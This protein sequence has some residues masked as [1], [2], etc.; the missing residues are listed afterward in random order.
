MNLQNPSSNF[1][2][3]AVLVS[4][5]IWGLYWIPL[6]YLEG[7]GVAEAWTVALINIPAAAAISVLFFVHFKVQKPHLR[8]G[9][10][11]GIF[12][13]L[14]VAM[15][16][17]GLVHSSVVRVTLLFYLTPVWS[18]LIGAY[19]LKEPITRGRWLAIAIGLLGLG[20]L[21]SQGGGDL[22]LNIGDFY[23][24]ASGVTWAIGGAMIKR[25][26]DVPMPTLLFF[27]F[28]LASGFALLLGA[29]AGLAPTPSLAL[30]VEVA[31]VS[32]AISIGLI[33]PSILIIFWAQKFLYPG[34]VSLLMMTE[35]MVATITASLFL[36][37]EV[38]GP[39]EWIGACLIVG[40]CLVE[41]IERPARS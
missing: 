12:M 21:V 35:V 26:G 16:T 32:V 22:P 40:A 8:R 38:M 41:V 20:F 33:F 37:D 23:G 11:I 5:A 31:S 30:L 2:S 6:R 1:A 19:W 4:A 13:G 27:Q 18:T 15:F 39:I 25:Y 9:F 24:L 36:P 7:L 29:A 3:A 28:I 34:R 14:T 10:I 17:I